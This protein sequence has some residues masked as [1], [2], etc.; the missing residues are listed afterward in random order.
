[1]GLC[2]AAIL[3]DLDKENPSF[4]RP[5]H[6]AVICAILPFLLG[7]MCAII[8]SEATPGRPWMSTPLSIFCIGLCPAA[9]VSAFVPKIFHWD[10]RAKYFG[11]S[12]IYFSSASLLGIIPWLC[13]L[14]YGSLPLWE[15]L[16]LALFY[17]LPIAWWC[18]R[19]VIYYR[20]IFSDHELRNILYIEEIDAVYY[21]Q[22]NDNW[23]IEKKY[24]FKVF[25]SNFAFISP[26]ALAF[27]LVPWMRMVK[28]HFGLPFPHA[29]L[30]IASLP[31]VMMI[32]GL[33]MKCY[34]TFFHYPRKI[35]AET[36]KDVYVDMVSKTT[37][38]RAKQL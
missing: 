27:L 37:K 34:L 1:V 10:W 21:Y 32:L 2:G 18:R 11:F 6:M 13:V 5:Q 28:A 31:V 38:R 33:T 22:K 4:A 35:K 17:V 25:P 20:H 24:K 36:G 26:L 9:L 3:R 8:A 29:F 12:T 16:L 7:A 30:T 19:F 14:I 15:R 23:L